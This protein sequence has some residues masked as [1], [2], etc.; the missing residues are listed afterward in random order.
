MYYRMI[1]SF[2]QGANGR[3]RAIWLA[4]ALAAALGLA[5]LATGRQGKNP[6]ESL[7]GD[8][9]IISSAPL[10][11]GADAYLN[12]HSEALSRVME[13]T[14]VAKHRE[15]KVSVLLKAVDRAYPLYGTLKL[16]GQKRTQ[17]FARVPH[18]NMWGAVLDP[19]ALDALGIKPGQRFRIGK[20]ELVA[21]AIAA[22]EPD[23][24]QNAALPR[25]IVS[26]RALRISGLMDSADIVRRTRLRLPENAD[27]GAW[28][29]KFTGSFPYAAWT[30]RDWQ[31][32]E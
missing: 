1:S 25:V 16:D 30:L 7:G 23:R 21:Q 29:S 3:K 19:A 17:V 22:A 27:A 24:P 6:R 10:P 31:T 12:F 8:I 20:V 18:R 13:T 4:L 5:M 28:R 26:H 9:E 14:A 2:Y 15:K 32:H 11:L